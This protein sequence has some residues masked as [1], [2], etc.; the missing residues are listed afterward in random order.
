MNRPSNLLGV[1]CRGPGRKWACSDQ[2]IQVLSGHVVHRK[3]VLACA[4]ARFINC[5]NTWVAQTS[6]RFSLRP[7]SQDLVSASELASENDLNSHD[8]IETALAGPVNNA[9]PAARNFLQQFIAGNGKR[10]SRGRWNGLRRKLR[11]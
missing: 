9:H 4:F 7:E 6:G 8:P 5:D 3:E 10:E 2:F 1:T 11:P